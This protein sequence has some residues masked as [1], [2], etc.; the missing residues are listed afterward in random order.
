MT[1]GLILAL[2]IL[3]AVVR[4]TLLAPALGETV[5]LPVSGV[6][7]SALILLVAGLSVPYFRPVEPRVFWLS[8]VLWLG[9]TLLFEV[10]LAFLVVGLAWRELLASLDPRDGNL[11]ILVLVM[12]LLAPRLAAKIR[13]LV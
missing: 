13:N 9:L 12:T 2:A 10:G 5:A 1:W 7:L 6:V 3:N 11:F 8:G 4:E